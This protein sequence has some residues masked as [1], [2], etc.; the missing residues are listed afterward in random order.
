MK[1]NLQRDLFEKYPL[2]FVDKGSSK[3]TS[4][5]TQRG[6]ECAGWLNPLANLPASLKSRI[7]VWQNKNKS[8]K[9]N[10][11]ERLK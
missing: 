8:I 4:P 10:T 7:E 3:A 5:F 11:P 9:I 1:E 2:V 6:I